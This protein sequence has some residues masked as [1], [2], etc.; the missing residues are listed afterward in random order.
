M[1][2]EAKKG[3]L[4]TWAKVLI[5]LV[6]VGV[7]VFI[8]GVVGLI[9]FFQKTVKEAQDP[10]AIAKTAKEVARFP[11]PLP[12]GYKYTFALP[13]AG[14][15]TVSVEHEPSKQMIM[16]ISYP[17]V[18]KSSPQELVDKVYQA[19]IQTPGQSDIKGGKIEDIKSRGTETVAGETMPYI[20]GTLTD[21]SGTKFEGMVGCLVSPA[22]KKTVFIY[23]MQPTGGDYKLDA[24]MDL[25]KQI[26]GF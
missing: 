25:L 8:I 7:I 2:S 20:V 19:G 23:G 24:T 22:E 15:N 6:L 13:L 14:I 11:D 4:P 16:F 9:W 1:T 5:G 21:K 18:E 3:G 12:E 26:K 17:Q 10:A